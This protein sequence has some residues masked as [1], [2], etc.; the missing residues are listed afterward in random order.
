MLNG[1]T[2]EEI[3]SLDKAEAGS[4]GFAG[5]S[6][7]L[8]DVDNDENHNL[9][10]VALTGEGK[11]AVI[12]HDGLVLHLSSELVDGYDHANFGL[13][14][15]IA[16]GDM[17]NDGWTE[18]AYGR[19]LFTMKD[20]LRRLWVGT[21]GAG[22]INIGVVLSHFADL[23]GNG[24][25]ELVAGNTAYISDGT[26]LY[27]NGT[28]GDGF[29][30]TGD[31]DEDSLPEVVLISNGNLYIL[32]GVTGSVE[33]GP[34][35]IPGNGAGGP[36]IV[37]DF[38]GDGEPEIGV[39][40]QNYYS[41]MKPDYN[42]N[43][44]D[45]LWSTL[46]HDNSSSIT[47]SS[48]FDFEGDGKVEVIYM[49]ECFLWVFDGTTGNVR[50]TINSQSFTATE[51][52][53]VADVDGDSQAEIVFVHNGADPNTWTCAHHT[54]GNDGY[55]I[56][57]L[58]A[59]GAYRGIT[60]VG[61]S[62]NS[63]INTRTLWNQHAYS[64]SNI[65]DP[66]DNGC[67]GDAHYGQIPSMQQKNWQVDW[68]NN[69]RQNVQLTT[70]SCLDSLML[71]AGL[72]TIDSVYEAAL[73][74]SSAATVGAGVTIDYSAGSDI[75]L[76]PGFTVETGSVFHAYILGCTISMAT[77]EQT[78]AILNQGVPI[79]KLQAEQIDQREPLYALKRDLSSPALVIKYTSFPYPN[80]INFLFGQE[81]SARVHLEIR[82]PQGNLVKTIIKDQQYQAGF[83]KKVLDGKNL[84]P[85][86]YLVRLRTSDNLTTR[87]LILIDEGFKIE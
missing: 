8:G 24:N 48:A 58:P 40:M 84:L 3:W 20:S 38:N 71:P 2:G 22:G 86:I 46:N 49:D 45:D 61:D 50:F 80:T 31:F 74:I 63:W 60:V 16:L 52:A 81:K 69:F 9:E 57:S 4:S 55:P 47:G 35:A 34:H 39:A 43:T 6:V 66:N 44:I 42:T 85:G 21:Q 51:A 37:A 27:H 72:I 53:I 65:C 87:K 62:I 75:D 82:S 64:V 17:N 83:H 12:S 14:G 76:V 26:L 59:S 70:P 19:T 18:I 73:N 29:T 68:L 25:L 10:I 79:K 15:G 23:N 78:A 77:V 11:V 33:I 7:A 67:I 32:E 5:M 36:P 41:M 1:Q 54:T 28:V 13:G 56:W 30:A